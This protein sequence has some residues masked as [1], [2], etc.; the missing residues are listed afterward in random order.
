MYLI[1]MSLNMQSILVPT[2]IGGGIALL[3]MTAMGSLRMP[4]RQKASEETKVK[5]AEE[6]VQNEEPRP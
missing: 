4:A 1:A 5:Q 6:I 2:A 3:L